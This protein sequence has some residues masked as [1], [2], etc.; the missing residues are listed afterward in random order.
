M[1]DPINWQVHIFPDFFNEF[2]SK[3]SSPAFD[4]I[5]YQDESHIVVQY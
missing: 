5:K 2:E 1:K 4:K 3:I